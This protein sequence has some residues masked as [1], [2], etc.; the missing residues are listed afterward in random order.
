MSV[1]YCCTIDGSFDFALRL[2]MSVPQF[3]SLSHFW[4]WRHDTD[5]LVFWVFIACVIH[6]T[7]LL[8]IGFNWKEPIKTSKTIEI[9]L[10]HSSTRKAPE[11]AKYLAQA[12]QIG[13]GLVNQ[14][15]TAVPTVEPSRGRDHHKQPRRSEPSQQS[16]VEH[17]LITQKRALSTLPSAPS[18]KKQSVQAQPELSIEELDQQIAQLGAK[19]KEL[20]EQSEQTRIKSINLISAHRFAAAQ[21]IKEWDRKVERIGNLNYPQINGHQDFSGQ[22][23]MDVGINADGSVY[24]VR[25]VESSGIPELDEAAKRIVYMSVPF[26]VLPDELM[27]EL[28]VLM[29]SRV[30]HFSE[31]GLVTAH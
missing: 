21:Y 29:I 25:I 3:E 17:R 16:Q 14:R 1:E 22:L 24:N 20:Q 13:A 27:Q 4:S 26:P 2:I 7:A 15:S 9:T 8:G 31:N 19:L 5:P 30:W 12:N 28:D 6:A 18:A 23:A 11:K 10:V